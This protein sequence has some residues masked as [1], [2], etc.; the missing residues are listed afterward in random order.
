MAEKR[1]PDH[2]ATI[3]GRTALIKI[4][5]DPPRTGSKIARNIISRTEGCELRCSP[6]HNGQGDGKPGAKTPPSW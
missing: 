1:S 5:R 4:M 6:G 3:G 2:K